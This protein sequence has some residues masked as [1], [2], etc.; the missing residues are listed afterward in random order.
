MVEVKGK[1]ISTQA[2]TAERENDTKVMYPGRRRFDKVRMNRRRLKNHKSLIVTSTC[3]FSRDAGACTNKDMRSDVEGQDRIMMN[4]SQDGVLG[5]FDEPPPSPPVPEEEPW[6]GDKD[7]GEKDIYGTPSGYAADGAAS[8]D[9]ASDCS[10]PSLCQAAPIGRSTSTLDAITVSSDWSYTTTDS[11][12]MTSLTPNLQY[13]P[14]PLL[15]GGEIYSDDEQEQELLPQLKK[16][17]RKNP[18]EI[19]IVRSLAGKSSRERSLALCYE[20]GREMTASSL[21]LR[22]NAVPTP[23][24]IVKTKTRGTKTFYPPTSMIRRSNPS[25]SL[26]TELD[27]VLA[28]GDGAPRSPIESS[29]DEY[30]ETDS[31][32]SQK[33]MPDTIITT[34]KTGTLERM[35]DEL[36]G[37][38]DD[39][40]QAFHDIVHAFSLRSSDIKS[41]WKRIDKAKDEMDRS[42]HGRNKNTT[43]VPSTV[44]VMTTTRV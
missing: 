34:T 23:A 19:A 35:K 6:I 2:S 40:R 3:S 36:M 28:I 12:T 30:A 4:E 31:S 38:L 20:R 33:M 22:S 39:T 29:E 16:E 43:T 37:T 27:P 13:T 42:I 10:F 15:E 11:L 18:S 17:M 44:D 14:T 1:G 8:I 25:D 24:A 7:F 41:V 9:D 32:D 5:T 21:K 26:S